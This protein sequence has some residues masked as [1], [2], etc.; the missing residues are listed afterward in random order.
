MF[1]LNF[2]RRTHLVGKSDIIIVLFLM[3]FS[4][5]HLLYIEEYE[6]KPF[7]YG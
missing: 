6:S 3:P 7:T 5:S 2:T 4:L 1:S